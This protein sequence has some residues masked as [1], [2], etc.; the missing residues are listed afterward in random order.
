M[1]PHRLFL[2]RLLPSLALL[3]LLVLTGCGQKQTGQE[4]KLWTFT[5]DAL[6][7]TLIKGF[8]KKHPG[9]TV[10]HRQLSWEGGLEQLLVALSSHEGPDVAELG[11]TWVARFAADGQLADLSAPFGKLAKNMTLVETGTYEGKLVALPWL[12]GSRAMFF[13]KDLFKKAGLP[14]EAPRTWTDWLSMSQ[15][16]NTLGGKVAGFGSNSGEGQILF[17]R[18]LPLLWSAGGDV[19]SKDH[20][21]VTLDTPQAR[22]ALDFMVALSKTGPI[23]SQKETDQM[24]V[25][26]QLGMIVS[27]AWL[28]NKLKAENPTLDYGVA[29]LPYE[30]NDLGKTPYSFAGAEVLVRFK[31]S[32]KEKDANAL[33]DWLCQR[34]Q[35]AAVTKTL[36]FLMPSYK[37]ATMDR[38]WIT[39]G[40]Q[41]VFAQQMLYSRDTPQVPQWV[42]MEEAIT[43]QVEK[44]L[45]G[46]KPEAVLKAGQAKLQAI[47]EGKE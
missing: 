40:H 44:A 10:K 12:V 42:K 23:Q 24:F 9:V 46:E 43:L 22:K 5:D 19:L 32:K 18:F 2:H 4:L 31:D 1:R 27:G 6:M 21:K 28:L 39:N 47:L 26:G 15:K 35:M 16:I 25:D 34:P 7:Q 36:P 30:D 41:E 13:N 45:A 3:C 38:T 37:D 11:S 17:K 20:K 33:M 29:L 14:A 8:E